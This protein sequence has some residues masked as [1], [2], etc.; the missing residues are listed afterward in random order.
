MA[1]MKDRKA[2]AATPQSPESRSPLTSPM[3]SVSEHDTDRESEDDDEAV[4]SPISDLFDIASE[5]LADHNKRTSPTVETKTA[6]PVQTE[7]E[8]KLHW[9]YNTTIDGSRLYT[10]NECEGSE[11]DNTPHTISADV[12]AQIRESVKMEIKKRDEVKEKNTTTREMAVINIKAGKE[13]T[14]KSIISLDL[15]SNTM[16]TTS[17]KP[18]TEEQRESALKNKQKEKDNEEAA[19]QEEKED[20]DCSL[21]SLF[22]RQNTIKRELAEVRQLL[23]E[24]K[25]EMAEVKKKFN[26]ELETMMDFILTRIVRRK[27]NRVDEQEK[28]DS[29]DIVSLYEGF[30]HCGD[31]FVRIFFSPLSLMGMILM[32]MITWSFISA[33]VFMFTASLVAA[34]T[35]AMNKRTVFKMM[36]VLE[37]RDGDDKQHVISAELA[38]KLID[39]SFE[40]KTK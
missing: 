15:E 10:V 16:T 40:L 23:Q 3:A 39:P 24:H 37:D 25:D 12:L 14:E 29:M 33:F 31:E 26:D 30:S 13:I 5:L 21:A 2:V 8:I 34:S 4:V 36:K 9:T 19:T 27:M 28:I 35:M 38:L 20:E 18:L 32:P 7:K 11:E 22:A 6:T 1:S 17:V